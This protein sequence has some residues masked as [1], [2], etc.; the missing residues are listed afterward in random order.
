VAIE[1]GP[2]VEMQIVYRCETAW[3]HDTEITKI[4]GGKSLGW[5]KGQWIYI[6][7]M[8]PRY[9]NFFKTNVHYMQSPNASLK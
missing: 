5:I 6:A 2:K 3:A 9:Q 1:A 8:K 7:F 4:D